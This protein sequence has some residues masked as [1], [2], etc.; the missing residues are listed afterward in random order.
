M[1][2]ELKDLIG[3]KIQLTIN[4]TQKVVNCGSFKDVDAGDEAAYDEE[5]QPV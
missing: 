4:Y 1:L 3:F 5:E 2:N